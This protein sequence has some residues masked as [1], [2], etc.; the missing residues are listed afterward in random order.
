MAETLYDAV[1]STG[2][3][4]PVPWQVGR[5]E[6]HHFNPVMAGALLSLAFH[7]CKALPISDLPHC[8]VELTTGPNWDPLVFA[9]VF[10]YF[11]LTFLGFYATA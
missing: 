2:I 4:Q 1:F 8:W 3:A 11:L 9:F 5:A 10:S 6:A 7:F